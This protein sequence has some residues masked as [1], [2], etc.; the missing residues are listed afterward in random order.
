M[1]NRDRHVKTGMLV[2][3]PAAALM[4]AQN[5]SD[6]ADIVLETIGGI[7]GG[8]IGGRLPDIVDPPT[9]PWHRGIGHAVVPVSGG[10]IQAF[11]RVPEYQAWLRAKSLE[12]S[13]EGRDLEAVACLL[14]SGAIVGLA[15]GYLAHLIEDSRTESGLRFLC[16][17]V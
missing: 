17:A 12:L 7:V 10:G 1:P 9:S 11:N 6:G 15:A 3:G 16:Q 5:T 8:Y 14:A 13:R 2:G 4:A